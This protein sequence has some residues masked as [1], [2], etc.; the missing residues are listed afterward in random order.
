[1]SDLP[2]DP[3]GRRDRQGD[4]SVSRFFH[5][6]QR[7]VPD[8]QEVLSIPPTTPA[9]EALA[10]MRVRGYSQVPV[11]DDGHVEGIFS[12]RAFALGALDLRNTRVDPAT[13]PVSEFL[14]HD[15]AV[16][17]PLSEE[18]RKLIGHLDRHDVVVVSASDNLVGLLTPMD[19]LQYLYRIANAFVLIEEIELSLRDLIR[20][21]LP[22]EELARAAS[23]A[24]TAR[25]R[26]RPLPSALEDMTFDDYVGLTRDGRVWDRF[27][28]TLGSNREICRMKLEDAR[29][30]RNQVFHFKR[31]ISTE[32]H[33]RLA[34]VR[35]WLFRCHRQSQA[36]RG[37]RR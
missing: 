11:V 35:D 19:V 30:L 34:A 36:G 3:T 14:G 7:I 16:Y 21:A 18:F 13:L 23:L 22:G 5:L 26:D 25:Y 32:E 17:A 24:L 15:D 27:E 33:Q 6:V 9:S 12:Y 37:A 10:M 2:P 31:E 1:M 4:E 28:G 20:A 8:R 29:E